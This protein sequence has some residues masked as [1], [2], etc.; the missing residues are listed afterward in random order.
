ML[1]HNRATI[2]SV[3]SNSLIA[4]GV[5]LLVVVAAYYAYFWYAES[6]LSKLNRSLPSEVNIS[7]TLPSQANSPEPL[8]TPGQIVSGAILPGTPEPTAAPT[9]QPSAL[10]A[11]RIV[12]PSI[13]VDSKIIEVGL[14]YEKGE[15]VWETPDHAVGHLKGTANPGEKGNAVY[16]GHISSP[17]KGE[18]DVFRRLPDVVPGDEF[19]LYTSD[20]MIRFRV[21]QT[22]VVEPDETSV[23]DPTPTPTVTLITCVPDGVYDHRLI[24][25]ARPY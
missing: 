1:N 12:I 23:I 11:I 16:A 22:R 3:V 5:L 18:G 10:P 7:E 17:L 19:F 25:T 2:L 15:L 6:Q 21:T 13:K 20:R 24:V 14:T 9:A 4:L 8:P